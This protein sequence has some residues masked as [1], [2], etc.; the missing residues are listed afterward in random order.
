[1]SILCSLVGASFTVATV[2]E[3]IRQKKGIVAFGNAQVDTAQSKF[4]GSSALFDGTD[5]YLKVSP[6]I[7]FTGDFTVEWWMR[8]SNVSG[9][10][11]LFQFG[12]EASGRYS[13]DQYFERISVNL[14][15]SGTYD[16]QTGVLLSSNTWYHIAIVRSGGTTT[17]YIDGTSRATNSAGATTFGNSGDLW[18]GVNS[19]LGDDY[20]GHLDEIRI[21]SSAR[22]TSGFTP[23]TTPFVN[24]ANTLL[25]IHAN[26][27][28]ASTFFEDDNGVR[29]QRSIVSSGASTSTTQSK[30]GGT[31][32]SF[33][34]TNYLAVYG[35]ST[36]TWALSGD[37]TVEFWFY[38]T[39]SSNATYIDSR[40]GSN[41][42]ALNIL[43]VSQKL[44]WYASG[45]FLIQ[46]AGTISLNTWT[47]CALVRSG[48]TFTLYKNGTSVGTYSSS[49]TFASQLTLA[50]GTAN[51][52][53]FGANSSSHFQDEIRISNN[54][55]YTANFT[56]ATTPFVNDANTLLLI[57]ADG[58]N[59]ATVFR[60][61]N[62]AQRSP[63]GMQAVGNAAISTTQSKFGGSSAVFD[64]TGDYVVLPASR[65][66]FGT[67]NWTIEGWYRSS[68]TSGDQYLMNFKVPT[69][70]ISGIADID[71]GNG[72]WGINIYQ[73]NWRA[74]AFNNKLVGGVGSG[75][76]TGI[77]TT[78]WHHF[79]L[80]RDSSTTLKYYIDGTQ[81]GSTVTLSSSDNFTPSIAYIGSFYFSTTNTSWNGYLDEIR[82]S[83]TARY[84]ANFTAPTAPFQNDASTLLLLHCDGTN[85]STVFIDDNGIAPYTP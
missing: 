56:P 7:T 62:G 60:D 48:S 8:P 70:Q 27:T 82:I 9:N 23:S 50:I 83:N 24:D 38:Q 12:N 47:H 34:G 64:A 28:D 32:A 69:S 45:G 81:I 66:A 57:H 18:I 4:G 77:D 25:L 14:Y 84:T 6:G 49:S 30:F 53:D 39:S 16:A 71:S 5:D 31:S 42:F 52:P 59:A 35:D 37:L 67:G 61:D 54:A 43:Q 41:S 26:G 33:S 44:T 55:R 79:A 10:K 58:T 76:N 78:T 72:H 17:I 51:S 3:V 2:A 40:N 74:G 36:S 22:Y 73:N 1:M 21:S 65:L 63:M 85:A 11:K 19:S 68:T 75:V 80:V 15:G 29:A 13:I 46:E 20:N